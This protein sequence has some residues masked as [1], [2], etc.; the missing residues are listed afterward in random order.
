MAE[1]ALLNEGTIQVTRRRL[2]L[3]DHTYLLSDITA[4]H[5]TTGPLP[6]ILVVLAIL[7]GITALTSG[8]QAGSLAVGLLGL[9]FLGLAAVLWWRARHTYRLVLRTPKG[10]TPVLVSTNRQ[11]INRVVDAI[12][13]VIVARG[14]AGE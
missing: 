5:I 13:A 10:E 7:L 12:D 11:L 3:P 1:P 8:L 4:V 6:R 2:V 9:A 14:R